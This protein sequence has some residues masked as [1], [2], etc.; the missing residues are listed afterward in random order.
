MGPHICS[1]SC[2]VILR[3]WLK[4]KNQSMAFPSFM[5]CREPTDLTHDGY[6]SLTSPINPGLSLKKRGRIQYSNL[7]SVTQPILH[8]VSYQF[9]LHLDIE[10]ENEDSVEGEPNMISTSHDPNF[11]QKYFTSYRLS[12]AERD[13]DLSREKTTFRVNTA[14]ME[15]SET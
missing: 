11:E 4:N 6:F 9:A 15:S 10:V 5:V 12:Q 13:P 7:L 8:S 14:A 3:G 1:N 2:S